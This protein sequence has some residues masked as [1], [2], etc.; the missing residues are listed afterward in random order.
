MMWL[1]KSGDAFD[2]FIKRSKRRG[3]TSQV[4]FKVSHSKNWKKIHALKNLKAMVSKKVGAKRKVA[5]SAE[6]VTDDPNVSIPP[7][8]EWHP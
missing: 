5:D 8:N 6:D 2:I 1:I 4:A 7:M 3:A